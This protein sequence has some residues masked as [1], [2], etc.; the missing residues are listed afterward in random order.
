MTTNNSGASKSKDEIIREMIRHEDNLISARMGWMNALQGFLFTAFGMT[1]VEV[2]KNPDSKEKYCVL[3]SLYSVV[4]IIVAIL[5]LYGI[6]LATRAIENLLD[7]WNKISENRLGEHNCIFEPDVI[8][9]R[10]DANLLPWKLLPWL[11][12]FV[13]AIL[14]TY[15][16]A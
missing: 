11:F 1:V 5:T 4:G 9:L 15:S 10:S 16:C 14:I 7:C 2:I 3:T 13:W 12:I 6:S 8:G